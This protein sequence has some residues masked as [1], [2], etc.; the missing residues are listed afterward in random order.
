MASSSTIMPVLYKKDAHG[1]TR[2]WSVMS[3]ASDDGEDQYTTSSGILG[4]T[5]KNFT[6]TLTKS[7]LK[8]GLQFKMQSEWNRKLKTGMS[9]NKEDDQNSRSP[10]FPISPTLATDYSPPLP[11]GQSYTVQYKYDGVLCIGSLRDGIPMLH[12]RGREPIPFCSHILR[13]VKTILSQISDKWNPEEFHLVGELYI[14]GLPLEHLTSVVR[15]K[16]GVMDPKNPDV[17]YIVYDL[18]TSHEEHTYSIR[19]KMLDLLFL[20]NN[21]SSSVVLLAPTIAEGCTGSEDEVS[22]LIQHAEELGYEG[23]VLRHPDMLYYRRIRY[24]NPS[25]IKA[26]SSMDKEV[27][28]VGASEANNNQQGCILF[29]VQDEQGR[30]FT[31]TPMGEL[32]ERRE[33]WKK[34]QENPSQFLGKLYKIKYNSCNSYGVPKFARGLGFR[35]AWDM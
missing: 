6:K 19:K 32:E 22:T 17:R 27:P 24:R 31:V 9:T 21:K 14:H 28:I 11:V 30:E 34:F 13:E 4:G 8:S 15:G 25:L 2:F 16:N 20:K 1:N 23:V 35:D 33:L 12:S 10:L 3:I 5:V 26:K 18:V 7:E 29:Q